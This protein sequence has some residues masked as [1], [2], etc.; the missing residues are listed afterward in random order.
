MKLRLLTFLLILV[1]K[2][3]FAQQGNEWKMHIGFNRLFLIEK[4]QS[5]ALLPDFSTIIDLNYESSRV[6][7]GTNYGIQRA[8][9]ISKN[10]QW[11]L[12]TGL[13]YQD[14]AY[15]VFAFSDVN[16][17]RIFYSYSNKVSQWDVPLL[18]SYIMSK[19]KI[20]FGID[21]GILQT[22]FVNSNYTVRLDQVPIRNPELL[23]ETNVESNGFVTRPLN[24]MSAYVAPFARISITD[25]LSY[26]VQ[27][28]FRYQSGSTAFSLHGANNNPAFGQW[29]LNTGLVFKF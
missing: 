11:R 19:G 28:F 5:R 12:I 14:F 22:V 29:G 20:S 2:S 27:P 10:K 25:W 13:Q 8:F 3:T 16:E 24:K 15:D 21:G 1:S 17:S 23:G 7:V 6:N 26:E 18:V 4:S 9:S